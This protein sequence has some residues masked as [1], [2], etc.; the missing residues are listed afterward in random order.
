MSPADST[1]TVAAAQHAP[2]FLDR[3]ASVEK[4]ASLIAEAAA[5]GARLLVFPEA[6]VPAY[7][8]WVWLVPN[9]DGKV[10]GALYRELLENSVTVPDGSTARLCDAARAAGIHV[11]IGVNERNA[12]ASGAS[13]FNT[14]LYISD[15]GEIL[16]THRKL[17]P[18]GGERTVWSQGAGGDLRAFATPFGKLGGLLCW[19]NLM[20]LARQAMYQQ[21]VEIYVAPTWDS[22]DAWLTAMRHIAREGGAFVVGCCQAVHREDVPDRYG[23]KALYPEGREWINPGNSCIVAPGGK[24]LA[25][26]LGATQ[27]ILYADL[28]LSLIPASKRLFDPA[29][30]YARPDVFRFDVR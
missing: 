17:M 27:E 8:D 28:D 7:P 2:V 9:R 30:H 4:A 19:E 6:F 3:E 24:L 21:G 25:G 12:E 14:L 5:G 10:L 11:A 1:V 20:P 15:R 18:T 13:L 29:G 26:P 16:G 22:S 23:F